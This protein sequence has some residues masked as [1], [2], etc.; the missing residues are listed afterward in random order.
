MNKKMVSNKAAF[1]KRM[2][3]KSKFVKKSSGCGC[4]K[5]LKKIMI[6]KSGLSSGFFYCFLH[7][8]SRA[9]LR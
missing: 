1:K 4:G 8:N 5:K 3:E 9:S 6:E 7:L 2:T